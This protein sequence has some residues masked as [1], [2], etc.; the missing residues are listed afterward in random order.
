MHTRIRLDMHACINVFTNNI[1]LYTQ[2]NSLCQQ[3]TEEECREIASACKKNNIML[4]VCHVLRYIAWAH[5]IKEIIDSGEIGD[6]VNIQ[7][8]EPVSS[9]SSSS[10]NR[11]RSG[12]SRTA[13]AAVLMTMMMMVMM[14]ERP[15]PPVQ[16]FLLMC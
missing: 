12:S 7:H 1:L 2:K 16:Q 5:K 10:R 9:S 14:T 4:A 11:S 6:V 13:A 3:V 8:T 15:V